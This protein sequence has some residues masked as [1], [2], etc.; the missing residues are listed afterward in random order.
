MCAC[1]RAWIF[2]KGERVEWT[3][4]MAPFTAY[5]AW[6]HQVAAISKQKSLVLIVRS[7]RWDFIVVLSINGWVGW[8]GWLSW[9]GWVGD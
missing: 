4:N 7:F 2:H 8:L 5:T 3:G 9:L 1:V 6:H